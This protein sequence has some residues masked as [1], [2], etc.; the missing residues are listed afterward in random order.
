M[1]HRKLKKKKKEKKK[2]FSFSK[3]PIVVTTYDIKSFTFT[4]NNFFKLSTTLTL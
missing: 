1:S 4:I 3:V 2:I